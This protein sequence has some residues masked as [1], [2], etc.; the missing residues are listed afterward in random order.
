MRS[1]VTA[2]RRF[3]IIGFALMACLGSSNAAAT[4]TDIGT[5]GWYT[6]RVAAT[7]N[8]PDWCCY[9]WNRG[10]AKNKSCDLDG[11]QSTFNS[12]S[13]V[14]DFIDQMQVYV[15][16]D[17][18]DVEKIR[19][20]S[21]QCP[22]RTRTEIVDLGIVDA[23][24]S[25]N[26]L[27]KSISPRSHLSAHSLAAISVHEGEK[28][29]DALIEVARHDADL[30]NRKDSVFWMSQVRAND[31]ASELKQL[32]FNDSNAELREHIAF[33][34]SQSIVPDRADALIQLGRK[35]KDSDVRSKAWF[36]LA[37]T[38]AAESEINIQKAIRDERNQGVRDELVFALSQLPDDRAFKALIAVI[39]DRKLSDEDREQALFWL[40][41]SESDLAFEYLSELISRR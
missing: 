29:R 28:S 34:L 13:D 20:V 40:A 38:G 15:L 8:A 17:R 41:Q 1:L 11:K 21:A 5:E 27:G 16:L 30:E 36:W 7:N 23:D 31:T 14:A 18:G 2:P 33:A 3:L 35:D 12:H 10:V 24:E 26:W 25:V 37:Q 9:E 6:W 39:E 19:I 4:I 32:M 22:V